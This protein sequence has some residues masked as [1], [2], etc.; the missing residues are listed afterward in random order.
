MLSFYRYMIK[1]TPS[2][3]FSTGFSAL[4]L[5]LLCTPIK[6]TLQIDYHGKHGVI[7][8]YEIHRSRAH[9]WIVCLTPTYFYKKAQMMLLNKMAGER[10]L[11][12]L[13]VKY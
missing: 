3:T 6:F 13:K 1:N 7:W 2:V 4:S 11:R 8:I 10:S 9:K 12:L 5:S